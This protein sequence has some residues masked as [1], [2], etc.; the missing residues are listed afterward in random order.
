MTVKQAKHSFSSF[1]NFSSRTDSKGMCLA[2]EDLSPNLYKLKPSDFDCL[3]IFLRNTPLCLDERWK[4]IR[5]NS[6]EE[7]LEGT[8]KGDQERSARR[9]GA[10]RAAAAS[11]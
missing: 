2:Q 7:D 3:H 4:I 5:R 1:S 6:L 9:A 10:G 8:V 11:V